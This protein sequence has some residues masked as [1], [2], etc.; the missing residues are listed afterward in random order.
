ELVPATLRLHANFLLARAGGSPRSIQPA[1]GTAASRRFP[2]GIA[3]AG[4]AL[5]ALWW[6]G[7]I[8]ALFAGE[9]Q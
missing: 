1:P 4:G 6:T 7:R 9:V 2:Y 3:I 5:A 8:A